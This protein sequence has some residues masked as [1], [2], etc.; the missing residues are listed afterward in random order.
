MNWKKVSSYVFATAALVVATAGASMAQVFDYSTVFSPNPI[1]IGAGPAFQIDVTDGS[2]VANLATTTINLANLQ[3]V[4]TP[5]AGPNGTFTFSQAF[6]IALTIDPVSPAAGPLTHN[7]TG[8]LS[9]TVTYLSGASGTLSNVVFSA[10]PPPI[11][12]NFG[13]AGTYTVLNP[14][15]TA[16]GNLSNGTQGSIKVDVTYTP[17]S[18]VPEPGEYAAMALIGL[19]VCG[20]M[21]RA[22]R[23]SPMG[24]VA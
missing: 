18:A 12:Y 8:T 24:M 14:T 21:V 6:N 19:S 2:A 10:P 5:P 13:S 22:R 15:Y 9:G 3:L 1:P 23:R 4:D 16:F 20:L 7:V 17:G 11:V